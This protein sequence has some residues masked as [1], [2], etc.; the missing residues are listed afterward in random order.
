MTR[1]ELQGSYSRKVVENTRRYAHD[2]LRENERLRILAA[3]LEAEKLQLEGKVT[4]S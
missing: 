3:S 4:A 2:L 1:D